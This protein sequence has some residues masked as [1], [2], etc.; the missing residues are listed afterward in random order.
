MRRGSGARYLVA[1]TATLALSLGACSGPTATSEPTVTPTPAASAVANAEPSVSPVATSLPSPSPSA[2]VAS[3]PP[4]IGCQLASYTGP[5]KVD[6]LLPGSA[7]QVAV[8]E[9][10]L[11]EG[12]CTS[13]KRIEKLKRGEVLIVLPADVVQSGFGPSRANG[14]PWYPVVKVQNAGTDGKLPALPT[15]PL[16]IGTE[17]VFGWIAAND[18]AAKPYVTP[19]AARCPTT[20][21]LANVNGMLPAERLACFDGP[22]VVEGTYG[23]GGCGGSAGVIAKPQWLAW[24]LEF[25]FLSVDWVGQRGPISLHFKP[26]GPGRP[27]EGSIIRATVHVDDPAS[28]KCS[29]QSADDPPFVVPER[30]AVAYCR[31]RVVVE[32]FEILGT[33]PNYAGG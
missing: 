26:S 1:A 31:E 30:V 23:C 21:D 24:P 20:V 5:W 25:D 4:Q 17:A 9:L 8:A 15:N 12:P 6:A 19:L 3:Q 7:V 29:L 28:V 11:R 2:P 16:N 22:I 18:G 10:N 32:S 27:P 13:S 14:F 33:D